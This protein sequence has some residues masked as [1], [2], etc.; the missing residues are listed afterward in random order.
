RARP[1]WSVTFWRKIA[2]APP[3]RWRM[4]SAAPC[5]TVPGKINVLSLPTSHFFSDVLRSAHAK[6]RRQCPLYLFRMGRVYEFGLNQPG[7]IAIQGFKA[8][9]LQNNPVLVAG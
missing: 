1:D 8:P 6:A 5:P 4:P 7:F 9:V 2:P 3:A